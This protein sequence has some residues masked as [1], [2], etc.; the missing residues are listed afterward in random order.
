MPTPAGLHDAGKTYHPNHPKDWDEPTSWSQEMPY[1]D[2]SYFIQP[3]KSTSICAVLDLLASGELARMV[4][5]AQK[6]A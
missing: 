1:Y 6:S 3:N 2:Y 4:A 5:E